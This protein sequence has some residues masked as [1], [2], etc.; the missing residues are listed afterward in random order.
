M[1]ASVEGE[2][3]VA[4]R[5]THLTLTDW[6]SAAGEF[7][8]H[9]AMNTIWAEDSFKIRRFTFVPEGSRVM[10]DE[11]VGDPSLP[12]PLHVALLRNKA[13]SLPFGR[14]SVAVLGESFVIGVDRGGHGGE[15][16]LVSASGEFEQLSGSTT[17]F[18]DVAATGKLGEFAVVRDKSR[19]RDEVA[20]FQLKDRW[21]EVYTYE[22]GAPAVLGRDETGA[23]I[24][25]DASG[26]VFSLDCAQGVHEITRI[27]IGPDFD[28]IAV[29]AHPC[30]LPAGDPTSVRRWIDGT[31]GVTLRQN[32][33]LLRPRNDGF[34]E[35]WLGRMDACSTP[36]STIPASGG[37]S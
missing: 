3:V 16:I 19:S 7:C 8:C 9:D 29:T 10:V 17:A 23:L 20:C 33:V 27:S 21:T 32:V 11:L 34:E 18:S 35:I 4:L 5:N 25:V 31:I 36:P 13:E 1:T 2:P 12:F 6:Q 30:L 37:L 26:T 14:R 24:G 22:V 15:L 28:R